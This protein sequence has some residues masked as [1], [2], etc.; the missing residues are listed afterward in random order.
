M[1]KLLS[2]QMKTNNPICMLN[3][4]KSIIKFN[5][6]LLV[7]LLLNSCGEEVYV[8]KPSTYLRVEMPKHEYQP[9]I[10]ECPFTFEVSKSYSVKDVIHNGIKTC[11][12]EIDLGK[13]NGVV[14]FSYID[15]KEPL[16]RYVNY[17]N[18]KVDEHKIKATEIVDTRIIHSN[19]RVFGTFFELKGDV[20]T[21]FQF[22][23]TDSTERF[24]S[25]VVYFNC[26]PKYDSL[27]PSI[28]Y[29]KEDLLHLVNTF[30]WKN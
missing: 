13:L 27:K 5:L 8:P 15:M 28:A 30:E 20:A 4:Q 2:C 7:V 24:V 9:Y 6:V 21:P 14:N 19:K 12:K 23:L 3:K 18:D 11:H 26:V 17:S 1:L 22:Y 16:S 29:L 25:G 10:N